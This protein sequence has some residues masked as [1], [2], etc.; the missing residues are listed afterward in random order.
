MIRVLLALMLGLALGSP[1]ASAHEMRPGFLSIKEKGSDEYSVLWKVPALGDKRLGIFLRLPENCKTR[2]EP[3]RSIEDAAYLERSTVICV[4]G[5]KHK[6]I[7][8]DGLNATL[9]DVLGRIEYRDGTTEIARLTP[10]SPGFSVSGAQS[11]WQVAGTYFRL[12]VEHI[13]TGLDHLL[14]LFALILLIHDRWMLVKT[15][16]AFTMAHTMTLG[17]A[18]L[19]YFSLPQKPVEAAIALSIAFVASE[20]LKMKQGERRLSEAYPWIVAFCFGLLHGF[21][22]AGALKEVGLPQSDVPLA[23]LMF[24]LGV[25]AGQ[26]MFVAVVLIALQALEIIF[27]PPKPAARVIAAYSIGAVA[28]FWLIARIVSFGQ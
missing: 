14:F 16:T 26:L 18:T 25:E 5:L 22:F 17:G 13:L 11:G 12:G 2:G 1:S 9:T 21:G 23:L 10:E 27:T 15:I 4:G 19:G 28:M 3:L 20:L 6:E 24:N 8:I 7:F